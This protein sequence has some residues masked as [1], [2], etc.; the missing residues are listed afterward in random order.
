MQSSYSLIKNGFAKSGEKRVITTEY[1]SKAQIAAMEEARKNQ[2]EEELLNE[3]EKANSPQIDPE[4]LLKR[5]EEIGQRIIQD[6]ENEKK[7]LLLRIQMEA[8]NAEKMHM[9]KA[10]SRE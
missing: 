1:V 4:E 8:S 7:A 3:K 9:K 2:L 6:A 5:Y 10:M